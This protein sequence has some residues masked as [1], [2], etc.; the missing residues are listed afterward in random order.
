MNVLKNSYCNNIIICSRY[1][2]QILF[3]NDNIN[4]LTITFISKQIFDKLK[5]AEAAF[6]LAEN[7]KIC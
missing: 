2:E 4:I 3:L 1:R 7:Q 6:S 5:L